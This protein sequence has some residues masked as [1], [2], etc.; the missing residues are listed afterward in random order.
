MYAEREGGRECCNAIRIDMYG[1]KVC[2]SA[3]MITMGWVEGG[4]CE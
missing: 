1:W 4:G 3:I 2:R